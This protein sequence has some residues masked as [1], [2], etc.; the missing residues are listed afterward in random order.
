MLILLIV[1]MLRKRRVEGRR[2]GIT[3]LIFLT[4]FILW[5]RKEE[6]EGKGR[7]KKLHHNTYIFNSVYIKE[8]ER[9]RRREGRRSCTTIFI[10]LIVFLSSI[11]AGLAYKHWELVL[12]MKHLKLTTGRHYYSAHSGLHVINTV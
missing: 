6:G 3:I 1:F 8:E 9:R 5:R 7:E 12:Y 11:L 10:L 4:V 2:I